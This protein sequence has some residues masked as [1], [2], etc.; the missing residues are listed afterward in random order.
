MTIIQNRD[1]FLAIGQ[2]VDFFYLAIAINKI[3]ATS[4]TA[5]LRQSIKPSDSFR[6]YF[7]WLPV[8]I[9]V[10]EA[11]KIIEGIREMP[12]DSA[13]LLLSCIRLPLAIYA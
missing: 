1:I 6:S 3:F 12:W 5:L 2:P 7:I 10:N 8:T 4:Q 9:L 11:S 13:A